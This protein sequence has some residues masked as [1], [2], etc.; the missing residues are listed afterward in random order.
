MHYKRNHENDG[1]D[2]E[3]FA[4]EAF[5]QGDF[6]E[7]AFNPKF[8]KLI[9]IL[10]ENA[11]RKKGI[12][13]AKL[14]NSPID[15]QYDE[16]IN[17]EKKKKGNLMMMRIASLLMIVSAIVLTGC[18]RHGSISSN[19]FV[20]NASFNLHGAGDAYKDGCDAPLAIKEPL[21]PNDP[22]EIIDENGNIIP[23]V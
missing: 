18:N 22:V 10:V 17:K 1:D 8:A 14:I 12:N 19:G 23:V 13:P 20:P 9:K 16:I 7:R 6:K 11:M 4:I 15:E 5:I 3:I 21:D 2:Y